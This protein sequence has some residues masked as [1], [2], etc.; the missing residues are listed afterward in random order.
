MR[1]LQGEGLTAWAGRRA[2]APAPLP[3]RRVDPAAGA[4]EPGADGGGAQVLPPRLPRERVLTRRPALVLRTP[5]KREALPDVL[6]RCEVARLLLVIDGD[7]VWNAA[8]AAAS[9]TS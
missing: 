7:E 3:R 9:V 5:K 8:S 4:L 2:G 1:F 6:N